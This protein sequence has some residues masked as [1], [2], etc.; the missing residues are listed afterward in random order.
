MISASDCD[1][2]AIS[3]TAWAFSPLCCTTVPLLHATAS[4]AISRRKDSRNVSGMLWAM[5]RGGDT[6]L[7][8]S[9]LD[10]WS[11]E[12]VSFDSGTLGVMLMLT[13]WEEEGTLQLRLEMAMLHSDALQLP[14]A[15]TGLVKRCP[16]QRLA[17]FAGLESSMHGGGYNK[18]ARV[19]E[20]VE[21]WPG[22]IT[23][24]WSLLRAVEE[25][26]FRGSWLKVAGDTKAAVLEASL[27]AQ[28]PHPTCPDG[29]MGRAEVAVELG[30]YVGY[31]TVRLAWRLSQQRERCFVGHVVS[32]ELDPVHV[33][34]A[35]HFLTL[36]QE[37]VRAE[38]WTGLTYDLQARLPE[39]FGMRSAGFTFMDHRGTKF[40]DDLCAIEALG[41]QPGYPVYVADNVAKPGAPLLLW[42]LLRSWDVL[43]NWYSA[44]AWSM[45]EFL[46]SDAED[47]ML[48]AFLG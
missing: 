14:R 42:H 8:R 33:L 25:F 15:L 41:L 40:H 16:E 34:L 39:V 19:V 43:G 2:R 27:M 46:H 20:L 37:S 11:F 23:G 36:A 24:A 17:S 21:S 22:G 35:R 31:T 45:I 13:E 38:V 44:T 9:V 48:V 4:A 26:A 6:D 1:T 18:L 32:L 29:D 3:T 28:Q 7:A 12:G 47:W 5:W 10:E 30:T